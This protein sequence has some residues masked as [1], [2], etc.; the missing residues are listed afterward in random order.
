MKYVVCLL[1][2]TRHIVVTSAKKF[3]CVCVSLGCGRVL[4]WYFALVRWWCIFVCV[5]KHPQEAPKASR[6]PEMHNVFFSGGWSVVERQW[7]RE[8]VGGVERWEEDEDVGVVWEGTC[9]GGGWEKVRR[10][11]MFV[12]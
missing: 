7:R 12:W 10:W 1:H 6:P 5:N 2:T 11:E 9:V 4:L 3:V 8:G